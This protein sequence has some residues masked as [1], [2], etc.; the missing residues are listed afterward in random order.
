MSGMG[1]EADIQRLGLL[2]M[3]SDFRLFDHIND[4]AFSLMPTRA[5]LNGH[6]EQ[7]FDFDQVCNLCADV[8]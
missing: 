1:W 2:R 7:T 4:S 5:A 8:L 6:G 3:V